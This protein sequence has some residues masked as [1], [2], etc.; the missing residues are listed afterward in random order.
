MRKL[1]WFEKVLIF[2]L[3]FGVGILVGTVVE[4]GSV[5]K[6]PLEFDNVIK[7]DLSK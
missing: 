6:L 7:I 1:D 2:W 5:T 3:I 4:R